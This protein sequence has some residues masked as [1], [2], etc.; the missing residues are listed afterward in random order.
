MLGHFS[1]STQMWLNKKLVW[2]IC[3]NAKMLIN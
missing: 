3:Q 1:N 2:R